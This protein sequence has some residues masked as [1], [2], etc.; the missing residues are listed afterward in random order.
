M[1]ICYSVRL[2]IFPSFSPADAAMPK[3][4]SH[5]K[6]KSH[7]GLLKRIKITKSG[8]IKYKSPRGRHLKSNKSG[9]TVRGYRRAQYAQSGDIKKLEAILHRPLRSQEQHMADRAAK[10]K[11]AEAAEAK[12]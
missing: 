3:D 6:V 10:E 11:A 9:A 4:K 7:K 5:T 1:E 2:S 12:S 8:K